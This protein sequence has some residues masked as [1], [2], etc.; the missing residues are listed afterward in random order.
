[1]LKRMTMILIIG[2][3]SGCASTPNVMYSYYPSRANS[4]VTVTQT[5]DCNS[6]Q[7]AL[8]V[9]H[10]TTVNTLYSANYSKGPYSVRIKK[11]DGFFA[12]S[13]VE[14][15]FFED[16]RLKS[17]NQTTT[18]QGETILKSAISLA[19]ALAP[20]GAGAPEA[21]K[22]IPECNTV[23]S[24]G[25]GKPVTLIYAKKI[26]YEKDADGLPHNLDPDPATKGLY[27]ELGKNNRLPLLQVTINA[28]TS[29]KSAASYISPSSG[30]FDNV[31]LL[32][33]QET[34]NVQVDV[35]ASG[36]SIWS[37]NITIPGNKTYD[38]P[39]PKAAL[40]GQQN[41]ALTLS[42]AGAI[43]QIKYGKTTG[44]SGP[45]NVATSA[46]KAEVPGST[47]DKVAETKA[48]ADLIAQQQRLARCKANPSK[49]Q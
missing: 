3:L 19:A 5:I 2:L 34:E 49:C 12:D 4:N 36:Q 18:G 7:T 44:V 30:L 48:Q 29:I 21:L 45:L 33:L 46:V 1:M 42:E 8:V 32:T 20:L 13:S 37:G 39:I 25:G 41:F 35:G 23:K 26:D 24:W 15:N 27:T 22:P 47:S 10:S 6:D 17:I 40:F 28:P 9:V 38:L 11:L 31:V 43:T 14:F 16:G